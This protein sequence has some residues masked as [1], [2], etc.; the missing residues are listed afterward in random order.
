[1]VPLAGA[2][3]AIVEILGGRADFGAYGPGEVKA[4]VESG[5]LRPLALMAESR[6]EWIPD[7]PTM[8]ELG[9]DVVSETWRGIAVPSDTPD[10]IVRVLEDAI[11]KAVQDP[12]FVEF[13]NTQ[14]LI[15]DYKNKAEFEQK[16]N[17]DIKFLEPV[18]EIAKQQSN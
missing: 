16:I 17:D 13:M 15:I 14:S 12:K 18:I 3:P 11:E 1:M 9:I 7:V 5:D 10:E 6:L 4:H 2:A 8:R